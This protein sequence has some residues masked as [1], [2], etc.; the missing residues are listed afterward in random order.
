[1]LYLYVVVMEE[2]EAKVLEIEPDSVRNQLQEHGAEQLFADEVRSLFFDY[3]DGR[4]EENGSLRLRQR[5]EDAFITLK[6]DV[7][8]EDAK[9]ME[10]TEFYVDNA[11][12]AQAFLEQLGL[13]KIHESS[14][15][16]ETWEKGD[17]LYVIDRYPG[18]PPLLEIEAP[19]LDALEQAYEEL[20]YSMDD[21]VSWDAHDVMTHYGE[22]NR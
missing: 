4:I 13:E 6:Q 7:S 15:Y 19:S 18:V 16:R 20:G 10:E 2:I 9:V 11:D 22:D 5:G 17:V 1:M 21:T 14:K 3:P 8:R 12:A